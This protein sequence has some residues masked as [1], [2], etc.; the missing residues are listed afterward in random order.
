MKVTTK[1]TETISTSLRINDKVTLKTRKVNDD[2]DSNEEYD[3]DDDND[4]KKATNITKKI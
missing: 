1:I 3:N 2:G 4:V